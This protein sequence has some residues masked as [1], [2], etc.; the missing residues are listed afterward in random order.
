MRYMFFS[1]SVKKKAFSVNKKKNQ[2]KFFFHIKLFFSAN[3]AYFVKNKYFSKKN[4]F[5]N[6]V[7]QQM[8]NHTSQ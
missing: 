3:N 5:F 6:L 2:Y 4:N 1:F 8:N 7:L